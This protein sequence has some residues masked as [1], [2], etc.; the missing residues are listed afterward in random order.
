MSSPTVPD[1]LR[2][3]GSIPPQ[4]N[5]VPL[6]ASLERTGKRIWP[7]QWTCSGISDSMVADSKP[8]YN[9]RYFISVLKCTGNSVIF[10]PAAIVAVVGG[11]QP[12]SVND[13]QSCFYSPPVAHL[14]T[15]P[16]G[17]VAALRP[18][19]IGRNR[20]TNGII[21]TERTLS[22][23]TRQSTAGPPDRSRS[24]RSVPNRDRRQR[25]RRR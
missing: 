10:I 11:E 22:R 1:L 8:Y 23:R 4:E 19:A 6:K 9:S 5:L 16:T 24:T 2:T 7:H 14:S 18:P 13:H 17:R 12:T 15:T 21:S 25:I 3:A 20:S